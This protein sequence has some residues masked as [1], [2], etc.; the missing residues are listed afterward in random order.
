MFT[1][2][3]IIPRKVIRCKVCFTFWGGQHVKLNRLM[4]DLLAD[5][6]AIR[7]AM[8]LPID[9]RWKRPAISSFALAFFPFLW[10]GLVVVS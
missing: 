6:L 7:V 8:P 10:F 5:L 4:N 9:R 1:F 3:A 2:E